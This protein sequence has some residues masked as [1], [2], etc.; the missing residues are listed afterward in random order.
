MNPII[1]HLL[2]SWKTSLQ[3]MLSAAVAL[4]TYFTITPSGV[5]PQ[6]TVAMITLATGAAKVLLG[7]IQSDAKPSVT[8]SVT[9]ETTAPV[10]E[11]P[12]VNPTS[13]AAPAQPKE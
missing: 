2:G 13:P 8:S 3:G 9:I 5:L 11:A 12:P 10:S 4:G 6:H 1:A 7:L